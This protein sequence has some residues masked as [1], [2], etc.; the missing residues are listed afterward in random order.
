MNKNEGAWLDFSQVAKTIVIVDPLERIDEK[1]EAVIG[2][3]DEADLTTKRL[4]TWMMQIGRESAECEVRLDFP[5]GDEL[6][7]EKD[8]AQ[9]DLLRS[10]FDAAEIVFSQQIAESYPDIVSTCSF[11]IRVGWQI[12]EMPD[13]D[14][15]E[16]EHADIEISTVT[17]NG[18]GTPDQREGAVA[19][20]L[21][22]RDGE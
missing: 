22:D 5:N 15:L 17:T 10:R 11:G 9:L 14:N 8:L 20:V 1:T 7:Y 13:E 18:S 2:V 4:F 21:D 19:D 3:V 6:Q 16:A 12:V